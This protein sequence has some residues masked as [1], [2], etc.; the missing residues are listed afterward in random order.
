MGTVVIDPDTGEITYTPTLAESGM[1]VTIVYTV[2]NDV[3]DDTTFDATTGLPNGNDTDDI[4]MTA[5]LTISVAVAVDPCTDGAIAGTVTANDPDADGINN[6][7][8]LDD[9]ND[10]ILDTEEGC[11]NITIDVIA[12]F[13]PAGT[14][15]PLD[16]NNSFTL[17]DFSS[18]GIDVTFTQLEGGSTGFPRVAIN[19]TPA[20]NSVSTQNINETSVV[21]LTTNVRRRLVYSIE[22]FVT[23]TTTPFEVEN[24]TMIFGDIDEREIFGNFNVPL[25]YG[26]IPSHIQL[27]NNPTTGDYLIA[28]TTSINNTTPDLSLIHI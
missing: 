21:D 9:D 15:I 22:F 28:D 11:G 24:L 14:V 23:G 4:C 2:C 10:G 12:E 25:M 19:V 13:G 1:D 5:T 18:S 6:F 7:C 3:N 17:T 26:Q 27:L 16:A 20:I 8:D